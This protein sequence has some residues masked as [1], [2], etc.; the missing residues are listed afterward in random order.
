[1]IV[2]TVKVSGKGQ[3]AIPLDVRESIKL[4]KGDELLLIQDGKKIMLEKADKA[5]ELLKDEFMPL[6]KAA[7]KVLA[8]DWNSK[9]D[10]EAWKDL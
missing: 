5:S 6:L 1:M 2:K 8:R 9:E 4:S 10:E 7:E 3:I